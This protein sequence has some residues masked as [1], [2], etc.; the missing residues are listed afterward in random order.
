[1]KKWY[2][3]VA[4]AAALC[5]GSL[6]THASD[7][8][9]PGPIKLLIGFAAGGGADTQARLI[10]EALEAQK[11]WNFI[12]ENVTGKGG[13][14]TLAALKDLPADGTAIGLVVTESLAY[15]MAAAPESGLAQ[16]D[17]TP[18]TTTAGFQMGIVAK[19]DSGYSTIQDAIAAAKDGKTIRFGAMSPRLGDIAYLLGKANDIEFN[20][21]MVKGGKAVMNGLNA[22]DLDIGWGAGIQTKAVAAG[23]MVNLAS[24]LSKPLDVS[25][26]APLISDVGVPYSAGGYFLFVAPAGMSAEARTALADSIAA[27][28]TDESTKAGGIIKKAFGGASVIK[29]DELDKLLVDE[30]AASDELLKIAAE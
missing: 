6:P 16:S 1:M 20:I 30:L 29:G 8:Q 21:V 18:L 7:W 10:S 3:S 4:I 24:G 26:D 28:A 27:V 9:P 22:G 14:N 19:T 11:G 17:F 23:D 13:L 12:P 2:A 5:V 25:P 15:N